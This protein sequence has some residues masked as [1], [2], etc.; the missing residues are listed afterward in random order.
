MRLKELD[1][2][3]GVAVLLVLA[4]HCRASE[5]LLRS[6][7][8]DLFFV[9]SGFLISGLL[10]S[11]FKLRGSIGYRRFF[12]RRGFKIY[13]AFYVFLVGT[14]VVSYI[15]LQNATVI[16]Y[17]REIFFVQNYWHGV[18]DH[19]WSLAVEEHFYILLPILLLLLI[20]V[21]PNQQDPFFLLPQIFLVAAISCL[22]FRAISVWWRTPNFHTAVLATHDRI[23]SLFF[24]VLLAYFH[25]FHYGVLHNL[26]RPTLNRIIIMVC[27]GC[28]V[29]TVYFLPRES[30][31]FATFGFTFLYLGFGGILLCSLYVRDVLKG[32]VARIVTAIGSAA[33]TIGVYSYSI[34]L[35]HGPVA[36]WFPGLVKRILHVSF[37]FNVRAA[38][39]VTAALGLGVLMSKLV[40]YPM[41]RLRDRIFPGILD[42][43]VIQNHAKNG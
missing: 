32:R 28:L 15:F 21:F 7:W 30:R 42:K 6:G 40:E 43:P 14:A 9:L 37:N 31:F 22:A 13:P 41:L 1:I 23:D 11:E 3:R 5:F 20:R 35:W 26:L 8:V 12:I 2:L 29:S 25:H 36:A 19:T 38:I 34:Y 4:C 18:W 33:A 27:S 17:L 39:S 10:F 16:Q 24:G